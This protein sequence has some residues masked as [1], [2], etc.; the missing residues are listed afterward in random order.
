M[1]VDL[2]MK[3]WSQE[4]VVLFDEYKVDPTINVLL[5]VNKI[6][7]KLECPIAIRENEIEKEDEEERKKRWNNE[8]GNK[9]EVKGKKEYE[10]FMKNKQ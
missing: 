3:E 10:E 9:K 5:E 2:E 8:N 1:I 7:R 6:E 4:S